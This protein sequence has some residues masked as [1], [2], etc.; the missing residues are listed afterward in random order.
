MTS[1]AFHFSSPFLVAILFLGQPYED[2]G[3][4]L[5]S[6]RNPAGQPRIGLWTSIRPRRVGLVCCRFLT[7][8]TMGNDSVLMDVWGTLR[9][10][11]QNDLS[12]LLMLK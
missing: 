11:A 12:S 4:I 9:G 7:R 2:P 1:I 5:L 3:S 8:D 10:P 6:I